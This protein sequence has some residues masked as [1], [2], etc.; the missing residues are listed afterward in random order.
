[1]RRLRSETGTSALTE[2]VYA[3]GAAG[4]PRWQRGHPDAGFQQA[5]YPHGPADP[6]YDMYAQQA[7]YPHA[8]HDGYDG[9]PDADAASV[10]SHQPWPAHYNGYGAEHRHGQM[11][12][13]PPPAGYHPDGGYY[14]DDD[15]YGGPP[16]GF[17]PFGDG[18]HFQ[19]PPCCI[20]LCSGACISS[21]VAYVWA[22]LKFACATLVTETWWERL[23]LAVILTSSVN[24]ALD[25]PVLQGCVPDLAEP[26][27]R[28]VLYLHWS[29]YVIAAFFAA[30]ML[31][32]M[33]ARGLVRGRHAYLRDGWRWLDLLIVVVSVVS[34]VEQSGN[35]KALRAVRALR[36]LRP[37]RAVTSFPRLKLVINAMFAALPRVKDVG[38][39]LLLVSYAFA[40]V[41]LQVFRGQQDACNDSAITS[42]QAC[43]GTFNVT[44]D[45]CGWLPTL[46]QEDA[47]RGSY[48]GARFPR[49]WAPYPENWDNIFSGMLTSAK[50]IS[51]ENWPK[52]MLHL[53]DAQGAGLGPS[54]DARPWNALFWILINFLL[55]MVLV[56]L[57]AGIIAD[58]YVVLS[59][60]T[61]G[62]GLL[63]AGQKAFVAN[64][65]TIMRL[66]PPR[67]LRAATSS[68]AR[69]AA[70]R[71]AC[72][73]VISHTAFEVAVYLVIFVNIA[74][75]ALRHY[76]STEVW[77][78]AEEGLNY[79][80]TAAFIVEAGLK[81]AALGVRQYAASYWNCF[82]FVL[83]VG[84]TAALPFGSGSIGRVLFLFRI[85]R[86]F[87]L[88]R[89]SA[90]L[91]RLLRTF[92]A[93]FG[94]FT[95]I[96]VI[97][98]LDVFI[99]A[100]IGQ[101]VFSGIRR[102]SGTNLSVDANFDSFPMSVITL[103]RFATGENFYDA[104]TE[105]SVQAPYCVP[106]GPD[107]NCGVPLAV[108]ALFFISFYTVT[109][110]VLF[111]LL[112]AALLESF[113]Q[114]TDDATTA[115]G[116]Y[117]LTAVVCDLYATAWAR[118]DVNLTLVLPIP[119]VVD[120][121]AQLPAPLGGAPASGA[122]SGPTGVKAEQGRRSSAVV[123]GPAVGLA[124]KPGATAKVV[125]ISSPTAVGG[126]SSGRDGTVDETPNPLG[127]TPSAG[128]SAVPG[129]P[130]QAPKSGAA[131]PF[132]PT[133][134]HRAGFPGDAV[135]G[136]ARRHS[137]APPQ[138]PAQPVSASA[139][140]AHAAAAQWRQQRIAAERILNQLVLVPDEEGRLQ[141]HSLLQALVERA[142]SEPGLGEPVDIITTSGA[143]RSLATAAPLREV[144]AARRVQV[145]W[146]A[147]Q[148]RLARQLEALRGEEDGG[149]SDGHC[150]GL[151]LS[152]SDSEAH[153][154]GAGAQGGECHDGAG[155][156]P[157]PPAHLTAR[158]AHSSDDT[159]AGN[160]AGLLLAGANPALL[161]TAPT[162]VALNAAA[163]S[164]PGQGPVLSLPQAAAVVPPAIGDA[165]LN[166]TTCSPTAA[167]VLSPS[168]V[169]LSALL[170]PAADTTESPLTRQRHAAVPGARA[171]G[172]ELQS[173]HS[174]HGETARSSRPRT[175][176]VAE[177]HRRSVVDD[178]VQ[179]LF[180]GSEEV[181]DSTAHA[182]GKLA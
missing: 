163:G 149:D 9:G 174:S 139:A 1:M 113:E 110:N 87:K 45:L 41:G 31:V 143:T 39:V 128:V 162:A 22:T 72:F 156:P 100:C 70:L 142:S 102:G 89:L 140:A 54:R 20:C 57:V 180:A 85:A 37:L 36:A 153:D 138:S 125:P 28:L 74:A 44:G 117:R 88:V 150:D 17:S 92:V 99:F 171:T 19:N 4:N 82:D 51:G 147:R 13:Y 114:S 23:V 168:Q 131:L 141:F 60:R 8:T 65:R 173:Q 134:A 80:V 66:R 10:D 169:P 55:N 6:V 165:P 7:R 137:P 97:V 40:V 148:W 83:M 115:V 63:T 175:L 27:Y 159:V 127:A 42:Q 144:A 12:R 61:Q 34:V 178:L 164:P 53:A 104:A 181:A 122:V 98:L 160:P 157:S 47:C 73:A 50:A 172:Q 105:L 5:R 38:I 48:Y 15:A 146:R 56:E 154:S 167:A 52:Y 95:N 108:A 112:S 14:G 111:S 109:A 132:P 103:L 179:Q 68:W 90:G 21:L 182:P 129:T 46:A 96:I 69:L 91:Q 106:D 170:S 30:E 75:I 32:Q 177:T 120:I 81:L 26:C 59:D 176:N 84:S 76:P 130:L 107:A 67:V 11:H 126:A 49:M 62:A 43:T 166:D 136:P 79:A 161:A 58:A 133:P 78:Q 124:P 118:V 123:V 135:P 71:R 77:H 152:D 116:V 2:T 93:S 101:Q 35:L 33:V 64:V 145:V 155:S 94:S 86:I 29:D 151:S 3:G 119:A 158:V 24:L 16:G 25:S 18:L 121:I